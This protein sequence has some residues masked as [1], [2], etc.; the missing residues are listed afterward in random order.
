MK[1]H[2]P[3]W[4]DWVVL[5]IAGA[6]LCALTS[7]GSTRETA[8]ATQ[9]ADQAMEG[10]QVR[11]V[12]P[13]M[14]AAV[15]ALTPEQAAAVDAALQ[16]ALDLLT[17]GRESLAPA[18]SVLGKGKP[19]ETDTSAQM[20][21]EK[22]AEFIKRAQRQAA[23]ATVEA[24]NLAWWRDVAGVV[25]AFGGQVGGSVLAQGLL[26][27]GGLLALVAAAAK[28][29]SAF[30]TAGRVQE[31]MATYARDAG[32]AKTTSEL[33]AVKARHRKA[34]EADGIHP[35]VVKVIKRT[36]QKDSHHGHS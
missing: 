2:L 29:V 7:C 32:E 16:P 26:G 11:L 18:L 34:Q 22:P 1:V 8:K 28:A 5:A 24:E 14:R 21:A 27:G 23:R 10:A 12:G 4:T 25:A 35:E 3:P 19:I 20:A 15:S 9:Q 36:K 6:L 30:K 17:Q 31:A 13:A 33:E